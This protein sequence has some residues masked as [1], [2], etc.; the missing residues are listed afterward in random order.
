[1]KS[2]FDFLT[3]HPV[4]GGEDNLV[5]LESWRSQKGGQEKRFKRYLN[6]LNDEQLLI[7]ANSLI[8]LV[9]SEKLNVESITKGRILL[10]EFSARLAQSGSRET[11]IMLNQLEFKLGQRLQQL[12]ELET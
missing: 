11:A 1:M 4:P 2:V 12:K 6:S 9:N 8:D 10:K 3:P 7:E 5:C